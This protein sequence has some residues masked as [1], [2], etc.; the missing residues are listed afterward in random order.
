MFLSVIKRSEARYVPEWYAVF[1]QQA[2][3]LTNGIGDFASS[4]SENGRGLHRF[5]HEFLMALGQKR[6]NIKGLK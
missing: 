4:V 6:G 5:S 2:G 1:A 3:S